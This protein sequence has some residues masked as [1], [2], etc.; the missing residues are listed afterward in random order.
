MAGTRKPQQ[1]PAALQ[2]LFDRLCLLAVLN[3]CL[4]AVGANANVAQN[5]VPPPGLTPE[6]TPTWEQLVDDLVSG[7][8]DHARVMA[9]QLFDEFV[10]LYG[11]NGWE[12]GLPGTYLGLLQLDRGDTTLAIQRLEKS[13]TLIEEHFGQFDPRLVAPLKATAVGY[14]QQNDHTSAVAALRRAQ[15]L[16]HRQSGVYNTDQLPILDTLITAQKGNRT[17]RAADALMRFNLRVHEQAFGPNDPRIVAALIRSGDHEANKGASALGRTR[18]QGNKSFRRAMS[19]LD[20]AISILELHYGPDDPRLLVPLRAI[21]AT[22][23]KKGS[24]RG[25]AVDALERMVQIV[26][27]LGGTDAPDVARQMVEMGDH[28]TLWSDPRARDVYAAAWDLLPDTPEYDGAR[29]ELFGEPIRLTAASAL[30][31]RLRSRPWRKNRVNFLELEYVVKAN[32]RARNFETIDGNVPLET[33]HALLRR[34]AQARFRP[35]MV[36]GEVVDTEGLVLRREFR[37]Y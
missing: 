23:L 25:V 2:R 32:G 12:V 13:I 7:N 36:D 28:L 17:S 26:S 16:T 4:L 35:R 6:I 24:G 5:F 14:L 8:Q 20:K 27:S 18:A 29:R 37:L 22:K 9:R 34:L 19:H 30:E 33:R 15:N 3:C 31:M 11:E 1:K 10:A 21:A